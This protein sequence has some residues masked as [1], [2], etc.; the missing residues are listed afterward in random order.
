MPGRVLRIVTRLNHGGPLRQLCALVPTLA[1]RGWDGPV[2]AGRCPRHEP[3]GTERL[4]A[5]G[6]EVVRVGGLARG[7]DP[8]ADARALRAILAAIRHHR[9]DVVHTHMAKA[10]ALGRLAAR[11]AGVPAVHT[12]HGHHLEAPWPRDVL[13]R[14]AERALARHTAAAI[15]LTP[16]QRR[17]LVETHRVLAASQVHV[18]GPGLDVDALLAAAQG[19][20]SPS[21]ARGRGSSGPAA[22]SPSRTPRDSFDAVALSG[23]GPSTS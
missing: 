20:G 23:R 11:V 16:R 22:S 9:P 21:A 19:G 13:A 4:R 17:D 8:A 10:G 6:A 5:A 14:R 7:L 18:V 1:A 2:L 12:F 15:C 3:D